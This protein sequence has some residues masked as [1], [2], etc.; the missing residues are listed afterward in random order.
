[1]ENLFNR[2]RNFTTLVLVVFAQV[3]L[4]A[5]QVK[6]DSDVRVIRIWTVTAVTPIAAVVEDVRS[7]IAGF[8]QNYFSLR[9]VRGDNKRMREE[10]GKLK[11]E[12]QFLKSEL[13][14]ADR[15]KALGAFTS[16]TQSKM[17]A[18]RIVGTGTGA[19]NKVVYVD[20]GSSSGVEKGMGVVTPDGIVGKV[21]AAY[22]GSSLVL[23]VTDPGF[24]AGVISQKNKVR[25]VLKGLGYGKC[26][27]DY[28]ENEEKVDMGEEFFTSGDDRVFPRGMP[29]G[30]VTAVRD[31][32]ST[33]EIFV[34][35]TALENGLEDVLIILGG[36][37]QAVPEYQAAAKP[38]YLGPD[39]TS[40]TAE[41][42][43]PGSALST[44]ADKVLDR[45][46]Q[47]GE[48]QN[49]KYGENPPGQRPIDFNVKLNP[50]APKTAQPSSA[51]APPER[52]LAP[53]EAAESDVTEEVAPPPPPPAATPPA[54]AAKAPARVPPQH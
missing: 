12:N 33:K 34:V 37:N 40:G 11:L 9:D 7:S 3:I 17:L 49:H 18:A 31:G 53:G 26:R 1:M 52:K 13:S 47:I 35:P 45:Y 44:A 19:N 48:Q 21:L 29:V 28:V 15:A 27:V 2:Y 43:T 6:N 4:L 41:E 39:P 5:Y 16:Q 10:L 51:T 50:N 25:G 20:R 32:T 24:G 42:T 46:K 36:V 30:K 38:V 14:T 22:P 8:F 54:P 23:L